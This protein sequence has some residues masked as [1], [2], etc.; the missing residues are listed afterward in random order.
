MTDVNH[1]TNTDSIYFEVVPPLISTIGHDTIICVGSV[2]QLT[3][4]GGTSYSWSPAEAL[5]DANSATPVATPSQTTLYTV[6]V[7]DDLCYEDTLQVLVSL[8]TPFINAGNDASVVSGSPYQLNATGSN[9]SFSWSPSTYLSCANC[10]DPV[11]TPQTSITYTVTVTDSIGCVASDEITLTVGCDAEEIF[12]P[13]AFT[14]DNNGH[15]DVLF[16]RSTGL[17]DINYFRIFDRWG[18][19]IFESGDIN[20]GWDGTYNNQLM[21]P[22]VYL[23][24]MKATCGNNEVI[25][26]QGNITLIK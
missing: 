19:I 24:T 13:N 25:E 20:N 23:Y 14:P 10:P 12:I 17:I 18:K 5:S 9:G 15:N 22:G 21:P 6:I 7:S 3:A 4:G 16:V 11:A 8:S 1:C 2:A 26:K